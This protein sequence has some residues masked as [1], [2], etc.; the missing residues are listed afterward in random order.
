[1]AEPLQEVEFEYPNPSPAYL[2]TMGVP[3]LE[4][5]EP[6]VETILVDDLDDEEETPEAEA[7]ATQLATALDEDVQN[8]PRTE[9]TRLDLQFVAVREL[10]KLIPYN[11]LGLPSGIYRP[12]LLPLHNYKTPDQRSEEAH[13]EARERRIALKARQEALA[14]RQ[15]ELKGAISGIE[16]E[17]EAEL[18]RPIGEVSEG[19]EALLQANRSEQLAH[20]DSVI[21]GTLIKDDTT[22]DSATDSD[23]TPTLEKPDEDGQEFLKGLIQLK[24]SPVEEVSEEQQRE[25]HAARISYLEK[26]KRQKIADEAELQQALV[27][28]QNNESELQFLATRTAGFLNIELDAAFEPLY[29]DE[30]YPKQGDGRT[31]WEQLSYEPHGAYELFQ[32]YLVM[33]TSAAPNAPRSISALVQSILGGEIEQIAVADDRLRDVTPIQQTRNDGSGEGIDAKTL[34][35]LDEA[36][37]FAV[38]YYWA[39]RARAYDTYRIADHKRQ[40]E[41]RALEVTDDHYLFARKQ[42]QKLKDHIEDEEMFW[43]EMTPKTA[44]EFMRLL[45]QTQRIN[46]GLPAAAPPSAK[47]QAATGQSIEMHFRHVAQ[48][49]TQQRR[50]LDAG[51]LD[52]DGQII[53]GKVE[54]RGKGKSKRG[55]GRPPKNIAQIAQ[56]AMDGD[57]DDI[58]KMF[59]S[60][61]GTGQTI[62]DAILVEQAHS[63]LDRALKDPQ[64]TS[65]LQE[66]VIRIFSGLDHRR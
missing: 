31:F 48:T 55:P 35:L 53:E 63:E 41:L 50:A 64:V 59:H 16:V 14:A 58:T 18:S 37:K 40:V 61:P 2:K 26:L 29:Y 6:E 4:E 11:D 33:G 21:E 65:Q 32:K 54:S 43:E 45:F 22:L 47:E 15:L 17:I 60:L 24:E 19:V 7:L 66:F 9:E 12:D 30:G 38:L 49:H 1:M 44:L 5:K 62:D 20:D 46:S 8:E 39:P 25:I 13:L 42:F 56:A 57:V 27:E 51:A 23:E 10:S 28:E 36:Q 52:E 3:V 34:A